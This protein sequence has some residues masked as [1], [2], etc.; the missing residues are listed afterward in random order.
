[1][2]AFSGYVQR[3]QVGLYL[4]ELVVECLMIDNCSLQACLSKSAC[5]WT[6]LVTAETKLRYI[7]G[8]LQGHLMVK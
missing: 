6:L 3:D 1:M 2:L 4:I 7:P 8:P 5:L